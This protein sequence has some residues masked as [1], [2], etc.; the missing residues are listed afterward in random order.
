DSRMRLLEAADLLGHHLGQTGRGEQR[1]GAARLRGGA[2]A[3]GGAAAAGGEQQAR[4]DGG[5]AQRHSPRT[6]ACA[7]RPRLWA[8]RQEW[9]QAAAPARVQAEVGT[10]SGARRPRARSTVLRISMATVI[11]PTPPGTGVSQPA[12]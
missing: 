11:G 10:N 3:R 9:R 5:S 6:L 1:D 4:H 12:T 7:S 2:S 8:K